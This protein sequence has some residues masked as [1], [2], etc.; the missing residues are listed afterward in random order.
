M[1]VHIRG[2][3]L[4]STIYLRNTYLTQLYNVI[5]NITVQKV[6][7]ICPT[8]NGIV[9][10]EVSPRARVREVW[11]YLVNGGSAVIREIPSIL[12]P[13]L[14]TAHCRLRLLPLFLFS[15]LSS[16]HI[17]SCV[18]YRI[19]RYQYERAPSRTSVNGAK[20]LRQ[21]KKCGKVPMSGM[22]AWNYIRDF[23]SFI[24][25][26]SVMRH[27]LAELFPRKILA[28]FTHTFLRAKWH[29]GRLESRLVYPP[30][31]S[32]SVLLCRLLEA[33]SFMFSLTYRWESL[34]I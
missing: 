34:R 2:L 24:R 1:R 15:P 27:R 33:Q 28:I 12:S 21:I 31:S 6:L 18:R 16:L 25:R 30:I 19:F 4:Q 23:F 3:F 5:C 32:F 10:S 13:Y 9:K 11:S 26:S 20:T 29:T 17:G 8:L 7:L 22:L 14:I